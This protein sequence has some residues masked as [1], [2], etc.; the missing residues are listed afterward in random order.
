VKRLT[1]MAGDIQLH[2]EA[3]TED[4]EIIGMRKPGNIMIKRQ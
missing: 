1:N 2:M 4:M 3:T